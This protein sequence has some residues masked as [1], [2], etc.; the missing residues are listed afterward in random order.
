MNIDASGGRA[1]RPHRRAVLRGVGTLLAALALIM[2]GTSA[3]AVAHASRSTHDDTTVTVRPATARL[4]DGDNN[5]LV[6]INKSRAS[7][8]TDER[9]AYEQAFIAWLDGGQQGDPP[10]EPASSQ[11]GVKPV[12]FT[13]RVDRDVTT[14]S[15]D[16]PNLPVEVWRQE[17]DPDGIDCT[18]TDG[19]GAGLFATGTMTWRV[20]AVTALHF[21][22]SDTSLQ[23]C[24]RNTDGQSYQYTIRYLFSQRDGHDPSFRAIIHLVPIR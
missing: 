12:R 9:I 17:D 23:G 22:S 10:T 1:I 8:C 20:R 19:P 5:L 4:S 14:F 21:Q 16:G 3:P 15:V 7:L 6:F 18:A 13:Q 24:I 2:T 11:Q